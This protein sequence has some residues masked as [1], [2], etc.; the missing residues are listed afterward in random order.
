M[1]EKDAKLIAKTSGSTE[2][3][4]NMRNLGGDILAM[5]LHF[6]V[7]NL[8]IFLVELDFW[9][10]LSG[11]SICKLPEKRDDLDIDSDVEEE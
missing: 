7:W 2:D 3:L 6:V 10:K 5:A 1:D 9:K 8:V 4:W 11:I